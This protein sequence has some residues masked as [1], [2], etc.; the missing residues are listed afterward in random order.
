VPFRP[1]L[2]RNVRRAVLFVYS[3]ACQYIPNLMRLILRGVP[4]DVQS[5]PVSFI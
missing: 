2:N 4:G 3:P 1:S 5:P